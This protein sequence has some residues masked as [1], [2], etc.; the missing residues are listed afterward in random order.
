MLANVSPDC[1]DDVQLLVTEMVSN[2]YEHGRRPLS[3]RLRRLRRERLIRL[4]VDDANP[5]GLPVVG[6]SRL[7]STRG[8]GMVLVDRLADRWGT[9]VR[10]WGK[11][12][13]PGRSPGCPRC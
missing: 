9:A 7:G 5:T 6:S 8:R 1:V 3:A 12:L 4:E 13:R 10:C 2:S 11:T